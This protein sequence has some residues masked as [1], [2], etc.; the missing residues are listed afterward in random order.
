MSAI[1]MLGVAAFIALVIATSLAAHALLHSY[2]VAAAVAATST[3][4][5]FQLV[6]VIVQGYLDPFFLIALAITWVLAFA[7][8]LA[9]GPPFVIS[10][11]RRRPQPRGG[12]PCLNR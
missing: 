10:R 8:A 6:G 1:R 11:R 3:A 4:V 2:L 7:G 12:Q 5:L 9:L